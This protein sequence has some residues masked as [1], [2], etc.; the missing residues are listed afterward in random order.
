ML[1][2]KAR[3]QLKSLQLANRL[4]VSLQLGRIWATV[5]GYDEVAELIEESE[6]LMNRGATSKAAAATAT[7]RK[8]AAG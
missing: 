4:A 6:E 2:E 3:Q 8:V 5:K 7:T 1:I